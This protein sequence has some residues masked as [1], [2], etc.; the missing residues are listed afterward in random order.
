MSARRDDRFSGP[1]EAYT[2][3]QCAVCRHLVG[4]GSIPVCPAFPNHVPEPILMNAFDHRRPH[5]DE[6]RAV[7]FEP[8]PSADPAAVARVTAVLDGLGGG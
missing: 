1:A 6:Y 3:S 5:P 8:S 4:G 7:R 2:P